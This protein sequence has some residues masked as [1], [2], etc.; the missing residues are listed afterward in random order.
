VPDV[1]QYVNADGWLNLR[2]RW[3]DHSK[4]VDPLANGYIYEIWPGAE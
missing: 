1:R 2:V 3:E 4:V